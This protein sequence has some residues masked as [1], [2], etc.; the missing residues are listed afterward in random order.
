[1][2][3]IDALDRLPDTD[4]IVMV[5]YK[6]GYDGKPILAFGAR[7]EFEEGWCWGV[8]DA[9]I[10]LD[11]DADWNGVKADDEYI[12]THWAE[13]SPPGPAREHREAQS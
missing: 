13:V 11:E 8:A 2:N 4:Q 12:V 10:R 7:L 9:S 5:A 3:W 1:M 6:S